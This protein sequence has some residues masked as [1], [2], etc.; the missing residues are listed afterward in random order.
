MNNELTIAQSLAPTA[1][2]WTDT[3]IHNPCVS[4]QSIPLHSLFYVLTLPHKFKPLEVFCPL[5]CFKEVL[6]R[7]LPMNSGL[8]K[9][10]IPMFMRSWSHWV[11]ERV[12]LQ[13]LLTQNLP[14]FTFFLVIRFIKTSHGS[15]GS[16]G[17]LLH[18]RRVTLLV[19]QSIYYEIKWIPLGLMPYCKC[20]EKK[21][22]FALGI[23]SSVLKIH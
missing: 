18:F 8:Q 22:S 1:S 15:K 7:V 9:L 14:G 3:K 23:R 16:V 12:T 21:H 11:L 17:S 13:S 2:V 20:N 19:F 5:S 6:Q 4:L 10:P